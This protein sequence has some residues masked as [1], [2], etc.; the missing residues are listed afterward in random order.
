MNYRHG[1]VNIK[2]ID[3]LP[4]GLEEIKH[5]GEY[6]AAYGEVT[7][8]AHRIQIKN[9]P[10]MKVLKDKDGKIYLS[11]EEDAQIVHEEH[12]KLIIKKGLYVV[13]HE[14]EFNYWENATQRVQD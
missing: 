7:G 11:F 4:E 9:P 8:H 3:S 6:I 14:R 5:G 12:K 2:A 13:S 1:D 10:S